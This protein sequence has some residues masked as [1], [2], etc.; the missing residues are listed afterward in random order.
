MGTNE[1]QVTLNCTCGRSVAARAKDAGGS[2]SCICGKQVAV[3]RL[4]QLR[5]LAGADAFVTNPAERIRKLQSEGVNPAGDRC[6]LCGSNAAVFYECQAV[7]ESSYVEKSHAD[8]AN[9]FPRVLLSM[10]FLPLLLNFFLMGRK[11]SAVCEQRGHDIAV[12]FT[13][14]VC[15]PCVA[16]F[17]NVTRPQNATRLMAKVPALAELLA[18]YPQLKL[19]VQRSAR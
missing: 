2:I 17:G 8:K 18:Y 11:E 4:S 12:S 3:P 10:L 1:L 16:T 5:T 19:T 7:C 14:P 9:S 6:L 15:D 13:L